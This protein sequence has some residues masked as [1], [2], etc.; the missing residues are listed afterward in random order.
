MKRCI[1]LT[2]KKGNLLYER[3]FVKYY[4]NTIF[5]ICWEKFSKTF[6]FKTI[7]A[8]SEW[9]PLGTVCDFYTKNMVKINPPKAKKS[10][11]KKL[12]FKKITTVNNS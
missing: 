12:F 1:N 11:I 4:D 8:P 5:Q 6:R 3:D 7:N 9:Y 10:F 2:D